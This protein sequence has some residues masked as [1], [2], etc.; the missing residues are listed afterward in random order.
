VVHDGRFHT[1]VESK[2]SSRKY[3]DDRIGWDIHRTGHQFAAKEF[4][5]VG[6]QYDVATKAKTSAFR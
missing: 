5:D 3:G 1:I 2:T 4:G 6:V